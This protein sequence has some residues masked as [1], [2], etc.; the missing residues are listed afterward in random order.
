MGLPSLWKGPG[1]PFTSG[2]SEEALRYTLAPNTQGRK[3]KKM[4]VKHLPFL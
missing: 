4:Q 2:A 1:D 3:I